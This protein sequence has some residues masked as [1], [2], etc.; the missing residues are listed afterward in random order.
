MSSD[1]PEILETPGKATEHGVAVTPVTTEQKP[2]FFNSH[3]LFVIESL[4]GNTISI[5]ILDG[6]F[7]HF[8]IR[9]LEDFQLY[10]GDEF[11][12]EVKA[13]YSKQELASSFV[14]VVL[15]KIAFIV[16]YAKV[17]DTLD[18]TISMRTIIHAVH[19]STT[20]SR[21]KVTFLAESSDHSEGKKTM[22]DLP[23][24]SADIG[25]W[26]EKVI[27]LRGAN[28]LNKAIDDVEY[29]SKWVE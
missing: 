16:D 6:M 3:T 9:E 12:A 22:P 28:R 23:P 1:P 18:S 21:K 15:K 20:S 5:P 25:H 27:N 2:Y 11:A 29:H 17:V 8:G 13:D 19:D 26:S 24:F 4:W 7:K 14:P 10:N